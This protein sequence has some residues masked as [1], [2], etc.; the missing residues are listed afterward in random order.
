[1]ANRVNYLA[2]IQATDGRSFAPIDIA[3]GTKLDPAKVRVWLSRDKV[4]GLVETTE[5]GKWKVI[6]N[7]KVGKEIERVR[8]NSVTGGS[9]PGSTRDGRRTQLCRLH[10]IEYKSNLTSENQE[11][12]LEKLK[13]WDHNSSPGVHHF[14]FK[15]V[16]LPGLNCNGTYHVAA[17]RRK[18]TL[19]LFIDPLWT[20]SWKLFDQLEAIHDTAQQ[21][22]R[23]LAIEFKVHV[24]LLEVTRE[25]HYAI[26]IPA[27]EGWR[28]AKIGYSKKSRGK[29][30]VTEDWFIDES[31]GDELETMRAQAFGDLMRG[32]QKVGTI[33][34]KL[35]NI[36]QM[37]KRVPEPAAEQLKVPVPVPESTGQEV[38]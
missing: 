8:R 3:K 12:M 2:A 21:A 6:N 5:E 14:W 1:M 7:E 27:K 20:N 34:A 35:D 25:G 19:Q 33:E 4:R 22:L 30:W 17:G 23:L 11:T 32:L 10:G 37:L 15:N 36:E 16:A 9:T 38:G 18:C 24:T 29:L 26:S 13:G 31:Y 28:L